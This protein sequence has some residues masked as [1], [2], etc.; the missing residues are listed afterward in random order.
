MYNSASATIQAYY[1][2]LESRLGYRLFLGG[3]RHFGYYVSEMAWPWPTT[4]ALRAMEAKMLGALQCSKG[5]KVLDAGCGTGHV[6][7]YM[8]KEGGFRVEGI[9]LTPHHIV[10]ATRN[11]QHAG[12][13]NQVQ[14]KV[15]DYHNLENFENADFDGI[16]T[17]E[18][19][20]HSI[21]PHEVL[22]E[23]LRIL[24]PGGSLVMHE[25]DH[26]RIEEAPEEIANEA[27]TL[28]SIVCMP[29]FEAFEI[30]DLKKIAQEVGF[31]HV[32]AKDM[33]KNIVPMLWLFF[34][35]AYIPWLILRFLGLQYHFVNTTSG[36]GM[37][38]GRSHW[39]YVQVTARKPL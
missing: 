20:V 30:D 29:A 23:F 10:K 12:M 14:V 9:D 15:G 19:L 17:M 25:Y 13:T 6:A 7:L 26:C 4:P 16:Y 11:I 2:S 22:R 34:V 28:N 37:Y 21:N 36:V 31:E 27:K 38:V 5:A 18:T 3:T 1:D 24:K 32:V 39:R 35:F 8:A 33:S